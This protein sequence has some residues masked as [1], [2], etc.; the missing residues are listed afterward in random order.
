MELEEFRVC[1]KEL[2]DYIADYFKYIHEKPVFSGVQPGYINELIPDEAPNNGE[3]WKNIFNDLN[4]VIIPGMTH[5][6]SPHFHAYFP[7]VNSFP[8]ICADMLSGALNCIGF[9]WA[10]SPACTELEMKMTDW[11]GKLLNL[12]E[13]FLFCSGGKGGGI[14]QGSVSESTL[15]ALLAARK[16]VTSVILK[17]HPNLHPSQIYHKLIAYTSNQ[18]HSSIKRAALFTDITLRYL[19]TDEKYGLRGETLRK[20]IEEDLKNGY[21]PCFVAAT[22]GTTSSCAFDNLQEIGAIC[23]KEKLWLHVDAAYAGAALICP[24]F[25]Y[26]ANGMEYVH[27]FTM[28]PHKW[29]LV[30][31]DC[32]V[33]WIKNGADLKELFEVN[34]PYL[35]HENEEK[36]PDYRHWQIPLGR[37]FRSLKLW[38]VLRS[39]GKKKIQAIIRKHVSLAREFEKLVLKD[40]RFEICAP[41]VMGLVCFRMK[42]PN[43]INQMLLKKINGKRNILLTPTELSGKYVI[44]FVVCSRNITMA[45]IEYAWKEII[46]VANTLNINNGENFASIKEDY[47]QTIQSSWKCSTLVK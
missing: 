27:S 45:D 40:E 29:M 1:A 34:P 5:W 31:F 39:F 36:V 30:N 19:N 6:A 11:L 46:M 12:P 26:I 15:L 24:E 38:F 4:R 7:S 9:N 35:R 33:M 3:P 10:A 16:L 37:R 32:T 47:N 8:S 44:R 13:E 17:D 22:L 18:G 23:K 2:V 20:A 28:S 21:V 42:G 43:V 41:V 25:R 14:I